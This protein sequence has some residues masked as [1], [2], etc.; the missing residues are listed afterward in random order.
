MLSPW[1]F[2]HGCSMGGALATLF[3]YELAQQQWDQVLA[4]KVPFVRQQPELLVCLRSTPRRCRSNIG[5][6]FAHC[7]STSQCHVAC[8]PAS[9]AALRGRSVS[10]QCSSR[11]CLAGA[12]AGH[13]HV[14]LWK[15]ARRQHPVC[16]EVRRAGV[17]RLAHLQPERHCDQVGQTAGLTCLDLTCCIT[18]RA[19]G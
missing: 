13:L 12:T 14:W 3:A 15:P 19:S 7:I 17:Q 11:A 9:L 6:C 16:R 5:R 1:K 4:L 18:A 2:P 10:R 8:T